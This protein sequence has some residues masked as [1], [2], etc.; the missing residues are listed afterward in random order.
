MILIVRSVVARLA[1]GAAC[2]CL[3]AL[4]LG[5]SPYEL[6]P[7]P[8]TAERKLIEFTVF[9]QPA[10]PFAESNQVGDKPKVFQRGEVFT[11]VIKG[12][13]K[14]GYHTYPATQRS[15]DP[16]QDEGLMS[17]LDFKDPP[18][19][20]RVGFLK[21]SQPEWATD[22]TGVLLEF[23]HPFVWS[24]EF[25]A[26]P[27]ATPGPRTLSFSI[28][29]Q[30]CAKSCTP[31]THRFEIPFV[32]S[33][34]AP[35]PLSPEVQGQLQSGPAVASPAVLPVPE[36]LK[37]KMS[38]APPGNREGGAPAAPAEVKG[39]TGLAGL[40]LTT[41]GAAIAM[42]FTPCVFPMIPITV[43]FFLKRSEKEHYNAVLTA[44]VY[45]GTIIVVLALAVL[46]LGKLIVDLANDPWLNL[47][48]GVVLIVFALSLFGMYELELPHALAQF[49]SS[50]EGKGGYVGALFMA[51]TFTITS[52]TCTGPFLGPLL[53]A[54]K[55][56]QLSMPRLVLAAFVYS[57]TF[58]APF[59]VLALFP[60]LLKKL[61]KSGGWL[62]SVK[63][64]MGFLELAAALKFLA[65]TDISLNPGNPRLFNYET[66]ICAWIVLSVA[67]GL[68]L[69]GLYRLPHDT[70]VEGIG[71]PR[72]LLATIF[73]GLALY[74]TPA[75]WRKTPQGVVGEA[76]VAFAPLDTSSSKSD[77]FLDYQK[78]WEQAVA[79][80]KDIFIDFTGVNCTNCRANEL[81][82]FPQ[83]A[84][85][86]QLDRY[87]RVKMYTDS[88]PKR[89][90]SPEEAR[91]EGRRNQE[92]QGA[93]F[94]DISL[95]MYVIFRPDRTRAE[96]DGKLQGVVLGR[97]EG[98]IS[99]VAEFLEFLRSPQ[100][101]Q[102]ARSE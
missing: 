95:P 16:A 49:T 85:Q 3:L 15:A 34:A 14:P 21:E 55:E 67:C 4:T 17:R 92:L 26:L 40:L 63:V 75:L 88:V 86:Q 69:L 71:V 70:P 44:S 98:F 61:P 29:L 27:D 31:G 66:V 12:T 74:M 18:G 96:A 60:S 51:L 19:V 2:C 22:P 76:V 54:A 46:V 72:M 59:F 1:A 41:M 89:G 32:V 93:T 20:R 79:Q 81:N 58:A 36:N 87:V 90:L 84:V 78:A 65:N 6:K 77:E 28:D 94:K 24:Q 43:S 9:L 25:V 50:R 13:L 8:A 64:V 100:V 101:R 73:L 97:Y 82:V 47:G 48:L 35:L 99:N 62:N 91:A 68:Y 37:N 56:L 57:A 33:D 52:F 30:V 102:V 23:E 38:A 11:L 39:D 53:V 5:A 83:T 80:N 7:L 10:D 42:L 45:S